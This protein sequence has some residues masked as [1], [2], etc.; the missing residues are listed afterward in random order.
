MYIPQKHNDI[1]DDLSGTGAQRD[2]NSKT[3]IYEMPCG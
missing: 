2:N 3:P 1:M